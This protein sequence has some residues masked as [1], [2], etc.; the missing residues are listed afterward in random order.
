[1]EI[2]MKKLVLSVLAVPLLAWDCVHAS[3]ETL[4]NGYSLP[5][6]QTYSDK[7]MLKN[8]ALS[9]CIAAIVKD[10][11]A[12][13]DAYATAGAYFEFAEYS[14]ETYGKL[15]EIVSKY[16]SKKYGGSIPSEFNTM[17]CIDMYHGKELDELVRTVTERAKARM[18]AEE[19]ARQ[20]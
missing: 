9:R 20:K 10:E 13:E 8:W 17:K 3:E 6:T 18:E 15:K 7:D 14:L 2:T 19:K 4:S 16:V 1:M 11:A 12:R 5:R